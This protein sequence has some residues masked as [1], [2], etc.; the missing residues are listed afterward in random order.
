MRCSN[1]AHSHFQSCSFFFTM[2][3]NEVWYTWAAELLVSAT[4][5]F[6]IIRRGEASCR[7]LNSEAIDELVDAVDRWYDAFF[8]RATR[9]TPDSRRKTS[10]ANKSRQQDLRA[11]CRRPLGD[12]RLQG[13]QQN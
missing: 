8:A 13:V 5:E 4:G 1:T 11:R 10:S 7:P 9:E 2:E 12:S 3:N 6:E